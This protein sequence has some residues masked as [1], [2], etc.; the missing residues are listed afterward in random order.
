M[1]KNNNNK[2]DDTLKCLILVKSS[3]LTRCRILIRILLT[4]QNSRLKKIV[5]DSGI[6]WSPEQARDRQKCHTFQKLFT[7]RRYRRP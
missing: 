6:I 2:T 4:E 5:S 1:F 3:H 7:L